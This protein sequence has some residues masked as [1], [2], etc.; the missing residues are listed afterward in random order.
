MSDFDPTSQT[1]S[2][3]AKIAFGAIARLVN[4]RTK[5]WTARDDALSE[6]IK[7]EIKQAGQIAR[8]TEM[9]AARHNRRIAQLTYDD[10]YRK[11]SAEIDQQSTASLPSL[12][13]DDTRRSISSQIRLRSIEI[14]E[15]TAATILLE[16]EHNWQSDKDGDN[17]R[18]IRDDW[19]LNFFKYAA[20]AHDDK[21]RS[22]FVQALTDAPINPRPLTSP[23]TLDTLRFFQPHTFRM[24]E[25]LSRHLTIFGGVPSCYFQLDPQVR[26]I[27]S[28]QKSYLDIV[29][30]RTPLDMSA[31]LELGLCKIERPRSYRFAI[32]EITFSFSYKPGSLFDFEIVRLTQV[33]KEISGL[34]DAD[35]RVLHKL[36]DDA[37][38][39]SDIFELQSKFDLSAFEARIVASSVVQDL[40]DRSGVRL[41]L[42]K[43]T[44]TG[45]VGII[46]LHRDA[47]EDPFGFTVPLEFGALSARNR[48][49]VEVAISQFTKFDAEELPAMLN[50]RSG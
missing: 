18:E 2:A 43:R 35:A 42:Y 3:A 11:K 48:D 17:T 22:I 41:E 29:Y 39:S 47:I 28:E 34:M 19:L 9:D 40:C 7:A 32:G 10:D 33:G 1:F 4:S 24:F 31:M 49:L 16:A 12:L 26:E 36:V 5:R 8:A 21:I 13:S 44:R 23:R 50:Q 15:E 20:D 14:G 46:E 38:L 27:S 25:H 45:N 37:R 30:E 6:S